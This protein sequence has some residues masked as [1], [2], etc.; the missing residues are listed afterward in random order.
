MSTD[1]QSAKG[2]DFGA[3]LRLDAAPQEGLV[4]GHVGDDPVLLWIK[5]GEHHAVGGACTHY[6]GHLADGLLDGDRIHCPLH[7]AC[8]SLRT[9][10][11]L[12]GPAFDSLVRWKVEIEDSVLFIREPLEAAQPIQARQD[13]APDR[14]V[15]VGGG[16][17]GFAAAEMLR[18]RGFAGS[19]T[20]LS[21]DDAAPYDRPNLS[22]DYLAG[23]APEA[24]MPLR[25][26]EFYAERRIDLRL[27]TQV[28]SLDT[29][30]K[31]V[32]TAS[33]DRFSYDVLL[34]ATGA[35]PIRLSTPGF[36]LANVF[37]L[38]SMADSRAIA[39]AAEG[40]KAVAVIGGSFIGLEV[41]AALRHR[42]LAVHVV[43]PEAVLMEKVMGRDL[44]AWVQALHEQH[45]VNFHLGETGV[46]F[47][48]RRLELSGGTSLEV[49]FLAVGVGVRP[50]LD[51]ATA[52]GLA[53]DKGVVVDAFLETSIRGVYA[54]G[55]IAR[56]PD[57]RS[58][59]L[60]RVEHWVAAERQGQA[61]ALNMMG[62]R[63]SFVAV[64]FFWSHHYDRAIQYVGHA[65]GG[66]VAE[67]EGSIASGH[68]TVRF[69]R[70]GQLAAAASIGQHVENLEAERELSVG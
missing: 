17:A 22:K 27:S 25:G 39:A 35:E 18:R 37:T 29:A 4:A 10:E 49:D 5:D 15:I 16:A 19:L 47:D 38:R 51:L 52:A 59:E 40:A 23:T 36:D 54:A 14:I 41:A 34:L 21:A 44:G 28:A 13:T 61:A 48:G 60:I 65:S 9:G 2:Q 50:R 42:G 20:M 43:A 46:R 45:G 11:A 64:P 62:E 24:W 26:P 58:G 33:G 3:G 56:Y 66:E 1:P 31:A 30:G 6:G 69:E 63:A 67:T 12:A 53:V 70:D 8:F 55:D 7:H 57:P 68:A 32:V